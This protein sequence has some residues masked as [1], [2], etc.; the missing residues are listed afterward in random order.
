MAFAKIGEIRVRF[1]VVWNVQRAVVGHDATTGPA[2]RLA[3]GMCMAAVK[4]V[5]LGADFNTSRTCGVLHKASRISQHILQC[6][7]RCEE[8]DTKAKKTLTT[9]RIAVFIAV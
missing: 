5:M 2:A 9:P 3:V 7:R 6:R 8:S 1:V 4:N